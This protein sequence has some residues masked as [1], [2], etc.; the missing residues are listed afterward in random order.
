MSSWTS[1]SRASSVPAA[2]TTPASQPV[3]RFERELIEKFEEA[4]RPKSPEDAV[5]EPRTVDNGREYQY[6]EADLRVENLHRLP[7]RA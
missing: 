1:T 4:S 2:A 7:P 5:W 3:D 6:Y